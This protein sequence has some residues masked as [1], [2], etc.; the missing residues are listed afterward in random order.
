MLV[1]ETA[2]DCGVCGICRH[3][4]ETVT[5]FLAHLA[6]RR[7]RARDADH[8]RTR[9]SEGRCDAAPEPP[10]GAG[11]DRGR[12]V[13]RIGLSHVVHGS[14]LRCRGFWA[15]LV[16]IRLTAETHRCAGR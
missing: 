8:M 12:A 15:S 9:R 2:C 1:D 4:S 5:D 13:E 10:A 3:G 6:E 11:H 7:G 16:Q 14:C